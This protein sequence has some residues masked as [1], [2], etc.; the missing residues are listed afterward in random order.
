MRLKNCPHCG[1]PLQETTFGR[2]HCPN[3]SIIEEHKEEEN[4][5]ER[6]YIG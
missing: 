3:C 5:K 4:G 1:T 6:S 2:L